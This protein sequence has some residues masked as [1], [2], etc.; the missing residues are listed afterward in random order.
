[1][2]NNI[3]TGTAVT[4]INVCSLY[5]DSLKVLPIKLRSMYLGVDAKIIIFFNAEVLQFSDV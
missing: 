5:T 3:T 1:M 4:F 2:T